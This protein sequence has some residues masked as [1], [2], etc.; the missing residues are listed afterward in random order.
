MPEMA[1]Q[2]LKGKKQTIFMDKRITLNLLLNP[3][4]FENVYMT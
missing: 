3:I 4:N 2:S 1:R